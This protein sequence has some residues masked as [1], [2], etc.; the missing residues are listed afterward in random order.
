MRTSTIIFFIVFLIHHS[1]FAQSFEGGDGTSGAPWQIATAAQLDDLHN[2]TGDLHT[3]KH[4]ILTANIDLSSYLAPGGAG[5]DKWGANGWQPIGEWGNFFTGNFDGD[6]YAIIGLMINITTNNAGFFGNTGETSIIKNIYL[7]EVDIAGGNST[8]M[9]AAYNQGTI[10]NVHVSGTLGG[11]QDVGGLTGVNTG[12][13]INCSSE[14]SVTAT[15][16][17]SGGLIGNNVS[18]T[19]SNSHSNVIVEGQHSPGGL[20]GY[21][22]N[23][24]VENCYATGDVS[25]D[26]YMGGLVGIFNGGTITNSAAF[27]NLTGTGSYLGGLI[28]N[29]I[30]GSATN[31]YAHGN[32]ATAT[33]LSGQMVGGLIGYNEATASLSYAIGSATA[34][35][36][37]GGVIGVNSS[38]ATC[39][40]SFWDKNTSQLTAAVG[41]NVGTIANLVGLNTTDMKGGAAQSNMT[42]LGFADIWQTVE[43]TSMDATA[44]GYP[45]LQSIDRAAQLRAQGILATFNLTTSASPSEGGSISGDGQFG[46]GEQTTIFAIPAAGYE[47]SGWSG[48]VMIIDNPTKA[49]TQVT[50]PASD[51]ELTANFV[52]I[53]YPITISNIPTSG[54]T[55]T[56]SGTANF[57]DV[58][59]ITALPETGYQFVEWTGDTQHLDDPT[60]ASASLTMP[61]ADVNLTANFELV[62]YAVTISANPVA[63]GTT[64]GSGTANFG[65]V[66]AITALPET[67]YQF[68]EWTGDTQ[69]LDDPTAASAS[70]NMPAVGVSLTANFEKEEY[71]LTTIASPS[72][73][74]TVSGDGLYHFEDLFSVLAEAA[75][76]FAFEKWTV[77]FEPLFFY[78]QPL[79][80]EMMP[81]FPITLT[82]HFAK[83]DYQLT[84]SKNINEGGTVSG[85]GTFNFEDEATVTA[86]PATGYIFVN[87]TD[88]SDDVVSDQESFNY[89]MPSSDATLTANFD[90]VT[91]LTQTKEEFPMVWPNPFDAHINIGNIDNIKRIV[92]VSQSGQIVYEKVNPDKTITTS[93]LKPG[94]YLIKIIDKTG[95]ITMSKLIKQ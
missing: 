19:V 66:V 30:N 41:Y 89:P 74:G 7:I 61:A 88:A 91:S 12:T 11:N 64:T 67:G 73:G 76:G 14:G 39:Q 40:D 31:N 27:G 62:D 9:I 17:N 86:I 72:E 80:E 48:A 3:D 37:K 79:F 81:P 10:E 70:L 92:I 58:V 38:G 90:L 50:M 32:S 33:D 36:S 26:G 51:V 2:Y 65:D 6:G 18:A 95:K 15:Y 20:I 63:G 29:H 77:D 54:G 83:I 8:G 71:Q 93:G 25:G 35:A 21:N 68:V 78:E 46:V 57:G 82:A 60:A 87:W 4:F 1:V 5:Y 94:I 69:Y 52:Q 49:T 47:F 23:S 28:G 84:L 44:D 24:D 43:G 75:E 22:W 59:A 53:D 55:T 45:I 16:Q 42:S 85:G 56:G 34:G 13:I